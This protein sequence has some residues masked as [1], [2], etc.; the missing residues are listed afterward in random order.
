MVSVKGA[1]TSYFAN[2]TQLGL[3]S[4]PISVTFYHGHKDMKVDAWGGPGG[5]I[6]PPEIQFFGGDARITMTLIHYDP[7]VLDACVMESRGIPSVLFAG[8]TSTNGILGRTGARMGNNSPR[9]GADNHFIS[10][11]ISSPVAGKPYRFWYTYLAEQ[12][13]IFPLGTEKT[14]AQVIFRAIPYTTDPWG[15]GNTNPST[16]QPLTIAG[17]GSYKAVLYDNILDT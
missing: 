1:S 7:V 12:P 17:T 2:L 9:F 5:G 15:D 16:A 6:G 10:L 3:S 14:V 4:D 8:N 11:N 13:L